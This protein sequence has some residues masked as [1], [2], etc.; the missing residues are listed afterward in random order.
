MRIRLVWSALIC[1]LLFVAGCQNNVVGPT[2]GE[3]DLSAI[4]ELIGSDPLFT[5]DGPTLNDEDVVSFGTLGKTTAPIYPIGWG[6]RISSVSRE[7]TFDA[8]SDTVVVATITHTLTG[9]VRIRAKYSVS[10]TSFTLITKPLTEKTVR[11]VKFY[12]IRRTDDPRRNWQPRE[13]SGTAGGTHNAQ[14]VINKLEVTIGNDTITITDPTDYFMKLGRFGGREVPVFGASTP[15][16][17]RVTITST[18]R[19]TDFVSLHR[20]GMMMG[21]L[22]KPAQ[23]R[24]RL[25]QER[26][27]GS[28]YERVYEHSWTGHFPGRHHVFISALTRQSLFDDEAPFSSKVW[29]VPYIVQ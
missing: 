2:V 12:R 4:K 19:D 29:G 8:I 24:M 28:N 9:E 25:V 14:V 6:R 15:I 3:K 27:V 11:K 20:P 17:V 23:I 1:T 7:V 5:N 10:D 21:N 26:A 16:K 22:F 13:V 18:E